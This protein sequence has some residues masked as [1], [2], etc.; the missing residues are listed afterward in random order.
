MS[1]PTLISSLQEDEA[2]GLLRHLLGWPSL[3]D[4]S[5]PTFL[6]PPPRDSMSSSALESAQQGGLP[7]E[8]EQAAIIDQVYKVREHCLKVPYVHGCFL[9]LLP[10]VTPFHC[11]CSLVC[12]AYCTAYHAVLQLVSCRSTTAEVKQWCIQHTSFRPCNS[13]NDRWWVA[14]LGS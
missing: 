1:S 2:K 9:S 8:E 14:T 3:E 11:V 4:D 7:S 10:A 6:L 13:C 5:S 12:R